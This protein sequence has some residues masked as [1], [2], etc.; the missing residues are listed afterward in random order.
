MIISWWSAGVTSAVATKLAI[1][2]FGDEV[3]PIYFAIDSA[4]EDNAR[5]KSECEDWYGMEIEVWRSEKYKDQFDVIKK[6]RYVNGPSGARCTSE[7]KKKVRQR[8]EKELDFEGQV[9]GFEF[10]KKEINRAI[11]FKEQ[12]PVAKPFFPLIEKKMTKPECLHFLSK[13]GISSPKMY[14]LGYKN[15]NCIG[16]VK[17][18]A[19]YWNKIRVDFPDQ[20]NRMA[21]LERE[22]G[23]S[24]LRHDFLDE[25]DPSKGHKQ[26]VIMPDCG[27]FC[28]IEFE[29]LTHPQL[30]LIFET[31]ELMRGI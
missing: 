10:S 15:N 20:F 11:R 2:E 19:G 23:R 1:Q 12:Y 22:I 28:D 8:V 25:L 30:E 17:G 27:N 14:D 3:K 9:F 21:K 13:S 29:E 31:P 16:C 18:G 7:L 6:T 24:C 5:F 4:H 26:E